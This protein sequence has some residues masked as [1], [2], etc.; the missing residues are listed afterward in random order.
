MNSSA[1]TVLL[2]AVGCL[3]VGILMIPGLFESGTEVPLYFRIM[4]VLVPMVLS[5]FLGILGF[6]M[7]DE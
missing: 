7:S 1:A 6:W 3:A 5:G 4:L 2:L